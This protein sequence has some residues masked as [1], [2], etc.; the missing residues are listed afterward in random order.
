VRNCLE[1]LKHFALQ[2]YVVVGVALCLLQMT[3]AFTSCAC[4][5]QLRAEEL[6]NG[7]E[8]DH[9]Y[10]KVVKNGGV[11]RSRDAYPRPKREQK[12]SASDIYPTSMG[13]T[14]TL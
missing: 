3:L 6:V 10:H 12:S 1:E 13:S 14:G 11:R 9:D 2:I 4:A 5:A 8:A 7:N